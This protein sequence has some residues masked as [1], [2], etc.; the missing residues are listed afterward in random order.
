MACGLFG[1]LPAKRDFV[2]AN[3]PRPFLSVWETWLQGGVSASRDQLGGA[4]RDAYLAAPI[5]RFQLGAAVCGVGV[6]G[7]VMASVDGVGRYFPLSVFACA[8]DGAAFPPPEHDPQESWFAQAEDVL[9]GALAP[10]ATYE[11]FSAGVAA[12]P[13]PALAADAPPAGGLRL[14]DGSLAL[15]PLPT[16][17]E[18]L[19]AIRGASPGRFQAT[20][21]IW[22]TIGGEGFPPA[23]VVSRGMPDPWLFTAFLTGRFDEPSP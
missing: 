15:S 19:I 1:K 8:P 16:L 10:G 20:A 12:L 4:W 11:A 14:R 17:R 21:S 2:A 13:A 7:A 3:A 18:G 9:L 22:W 6:L 23:L 5:W